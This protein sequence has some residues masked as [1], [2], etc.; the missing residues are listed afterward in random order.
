MEGEG[1]KTTMIPKLCQYCEFAEDVG[2]SL[3]CM[4]HGDEVGSHDTCDEFTPK[5]DLE[6]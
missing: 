5:T 1:G 6:D 4:L 2:A 3:Q